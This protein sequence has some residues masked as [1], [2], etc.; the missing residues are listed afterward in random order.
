VFAERNFFKLIPCLFSVGTMN[1]DDP[2]LENSYSPSKAYAQS[3]LANVLFSKELARR[4]Q[5]KADG[6]TCEAVSAKLTGFVLNTC[7]CLVF[8]GPVLPLTP[9]IQGL[10]RL[11]CLDI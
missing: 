6:L 3:K 1:F 9:C 4:L 10:S 5:G 2:N 11:S 8:Q 7:G